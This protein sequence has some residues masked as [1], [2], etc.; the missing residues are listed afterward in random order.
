MI[1]IISL[2]ITA[3]FILLCGKALRAHPAPFYIVAAVLSALVTGL[4]WAAPAFLSLQLRTRL[5]SV[6]RLWAVFS[7]ALSTAIPRFL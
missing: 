5:P 1:F 3:A 4:Y 2:V 6:L 7:T